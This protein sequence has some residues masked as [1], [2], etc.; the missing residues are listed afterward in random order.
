MGRLSA[1]LKIALFVTIIHLTLTCTD[2][3]TDFYLFSS[4]AL[5]N[6]RS[7]PNTLGY[8]VRFQGNPQF[9]DLI[10]TAIGSVCS[11]QQRQCAST[12]TP[13]HLA[14]LGAEFW[15]FFPI[16]IQLSQSRAC[17]LVDLH[18]AAVR[19]VSDPIVEDLNHPS[20]FM[21]KIISL[22]KCGTY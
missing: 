21:W 20:H 18:S 1:T 5:L 13:H 22:K 17:V 4:T 8:R 6:T 3:F 12:T 7:S 19:R 14:R 16:A 9:P 11:R 10:S 15:R 2:V